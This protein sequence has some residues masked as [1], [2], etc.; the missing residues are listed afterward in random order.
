L[1]ESR[2]PSPRIVL[3]APLLV[4]WANVHG[5]V[6]VGAALTALLG[7]AELS[8][9]RSLARP[10]TLLVAPWLCVFATPYGFAVTT[11]YKSTLANPLL[12][13]YVT[14]WR[15][16]KFLSAWGVPFFLLAFVAI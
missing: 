16:P 9:R 8:R 6:V 15:S 5:A 12:A 14:E 2:R 13:R 3:A 10:L 4:L 7:A 1:A 11:Y